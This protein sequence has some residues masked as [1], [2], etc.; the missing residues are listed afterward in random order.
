[1]TE[2]VGVPIPQTSYPED[3]NEARW[4]TYEI[5]Y[6][7][8]VKPAISSIFAPEFKR[9]F[10]RVNATSELVKTYQS[11]AWKGFRMEENKRRG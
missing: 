2:S 3:E 1:M 6:T 10:F 8:L 5:K 9:E 11:L 4:I 7:C